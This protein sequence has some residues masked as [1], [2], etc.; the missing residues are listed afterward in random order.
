[1]AVMIMA[2][3]A[4]GTHANADA[5]DMQT[6]AHTSAGGSRPQQCQGNNGRDKRFH[7]ALF[8]TI[9]TSPGGDGPPLERSHSRAIGSVPHSLRQSHKADVNVA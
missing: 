7:D 2:I 6:N 5:A 9:A 1:M 8:Q 4:M 3:P